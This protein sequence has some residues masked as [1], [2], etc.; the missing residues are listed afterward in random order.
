MIAVTMMF[1]LSSVWPLVGSKPTP[2]P[3]PLLASDIL[4]MFY[5]DWSR[6]SAIGTPLR[7]HRPR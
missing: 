1:I 6:W 3:R 4:V 2:P 7:L 5:N